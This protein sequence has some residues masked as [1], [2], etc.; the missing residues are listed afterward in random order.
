[1]AK[2][3]V[4]G[5]AGFIGSHLVDALIRKSHHVTV[6]DNLSSGHRKNVHPQAQLMT[7]DI[8][9][10][11]VKK[12][13]QKLKPQFVFH[14]AA[15]KNVRASVED[16]LLD[17]D[18]N[19]TGSLN[20]IEQSHRVRVKKFIFSSTGGA[21]FGDDFQLPTPETALAEPASPYG[22]AKNSIERYLQFYRTH[23]GMKNVCLRYANVYGP[24]QDPKGE[25]GVVSIF[26]QRL[27][28]RQPLLINGNGRQTRDY[29]YID[30]VTQAN[31]KTIDNAT[32]SGEIHI[33][34]SKQTSV[35]ALA[36]ALVK[37][38]NIKARI[39]HR[40][41]LAGEV[42]RSALSSKLAKKELKWEPK[43]SLSTGLL[44]TWNWAKRELV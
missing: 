23:R 15:Q 33:G 32:R 22:I 30:D 19:I 38:S 8:R 40:L 43:T 28:H 26:A 39:E 13:W 11:R 4:T 18:I 36:R 37:V 10:T 31:L 29:V 14:F 7:V 20:I 21:M 12:I 16:P 24:R 1:M 44:E 17:A 2:V 9:S 42:M 25:A 35:N 3:I 6:V 41:P 34:T 27:L 5:G